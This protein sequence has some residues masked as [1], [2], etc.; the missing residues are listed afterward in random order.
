MSVGTGAMKGWAGSFTSFAS[1]LLS[2]PG[3]DG[4]A[5][6]VRCGI[7]VSSSLAESPAR[8]A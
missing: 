7:I 8:D 1:G 6:R 4:S 5:R 2:G 3:G